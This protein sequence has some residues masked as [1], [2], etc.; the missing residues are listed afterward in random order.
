[1]AN[2][3]ISLLVSGHDVVLQCSPIWPA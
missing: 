3:Q 1:M 2:F